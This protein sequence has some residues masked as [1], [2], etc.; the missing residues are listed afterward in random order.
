MNRE[1]MNLRPS[2][3]LWVD[4]LAG[5]AVGVGVLLLSSW[6]SDLYQLPFRLIIFMGIANLTYA[7]YSFSLAR[8]TV[9]PI[10]LILLLAAA[11]VFWA[12]VCLFLLALHRDSVSLIGAAVL[13]FEAVF[14]GGLGLLEYRWRDQL[15]VASG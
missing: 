15:T 13:V 2:Q 7:S 11:N 4:C 1:L 5:F 14:V 9:R 3:L 6:L 10:K 8:R 12:V